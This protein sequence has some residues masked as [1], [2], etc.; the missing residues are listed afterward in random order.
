MDPNQIDLHPY[1]LM[2]ALQARGIEARP[3]WKP[4]HMQ[5]LCRQFDFVPHSEQE[6][7]S[8]CLFLTA[9]CLPSGSNLSDAQIERV[10]TS[11]LDILAR[12]NS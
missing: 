2:R 3:S 8:S 12:G 6:V 1:Q 5:P 11:V 9:L 4:M 10:I 7:V